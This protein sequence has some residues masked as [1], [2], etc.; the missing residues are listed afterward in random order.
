MKKL[1]L[2]ALI[3][4]FCFASYSQYARDITGSWQGWLT[5]PGAKLR[6]V[7]NLTK[8][9]TGY[10]A[11]FDS[12]DQKTFGIQASKTIVNK[13]SLLTELAVM[14]AS[15]TGKWDG[16]DAISGVFKQGPGTFDMNLTRMTDAEKEK[17]G[18][19][20]LAFKPQ[21]PKAPFAYNVED[22]TYENAD[23][24]VHFG[25]TFTKPNGE[26]AFPAVI[27]IS[28]SGSQDRDGTIGSHK[29]YAVLADHLTK[30]GIAV[31]RVDDRGIG[32]TSLGND[33]AK[34]TS[35]DF[36]KDVEAGIAYLESR[37][38]VDSKK[39]GLVGHSEG[40]MIAPMVAARR[41][42][43]AFIVLLAGPGISGEEIWDYQMAQAMV[44]PA[45]TAND[46][47]KAMQLIRSEFSA[48]KKN[49]EYNRVKAD[50]HIAYNNWKRNVPDT[51]ETRLLHGNGD[52]PFTDWAD[53]MKSANGLYWINYFV[54]Y[55]PSLNLQK[56]KCPVL[57]LNGEFD[58]QISPKENLAGIETG[59][60]TGKNK[61]YTIKQLP[62]LNHMFQT[63]KTPFDVSEKL[64]E[65]FSPAALQVISEW[66]KNN[67]K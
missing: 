22:I 62:S 35:E 27:I 36:A 32:G 1:F 15:Y 60:Q 6:F 63:S 39:I 13:D 12:P 48:F 11:T 8:N 5:A 38:D 41:R 16:H 43:V 21:T 18:P 49:T 33:F 24:S 42:D 58:T 9:G 47:E 61:N 28:G 25:A 3:S 40:G 7:I 64:E 31:L 54:N 17:A 29:I 51:M 37:A 44:K 20:V 66:I 59:L 50:M 10:S 67:T 65:T 34:I 4:C 57:A 30:N 45:L 56:V 2:I 52:K 26:G 46:H 53:I 55:Q 23:K 19:P 14:K